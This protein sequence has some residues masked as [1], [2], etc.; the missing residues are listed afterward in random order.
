M[1]PVRLSGLVE[2]DL[3]DIGDYIAKANPRRARSFIA[4]LR[5]AIKEIGQNP[6]LYRFRP[7]FGPG[8]RARVHGRYLILFHLTE[9]FEIVD[10]VVQGARDMKHI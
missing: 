6:F 9:D 8:R 10:R 5:L 2:Y 1:M 7:E 4:E 3:D